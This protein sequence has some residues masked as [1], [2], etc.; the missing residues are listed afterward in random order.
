M[1]FE[2]GFNPR[3]I[4]K[5]AVFPNLPG[6]AGRNGER[7]EQ[8]KSGIPA[9]VS[10]LQLAF[11]HEA[12]VSGVYKNIKPITARTIVEYFTTDKTHADLAKEYGVSV[13]AVSKRIFSG[14]G[15]MR[16]LLYRDNPQ[17][18]QEDPYPLALIQKGKD[19]LEVARTE[20]S[21]QRRSVASKK[22]RGGRHV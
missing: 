9:G 15:K 7:R 11:L 18:A 12:W 10:I 16:R 14:M 4:E 17:L 20:K 8:Q 21:R 13:Q 22:R 6:A 19:P 2:R 1:H 5:R 3:P